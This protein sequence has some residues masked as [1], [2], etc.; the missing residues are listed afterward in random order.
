ML[1]SGVLIPVWMFPEQLRLIVSV[2]PFQ[3]IFHTPLDIYINYTVPSQAAPVILVQV[4]WALVLALMSIALW[5]RTSSR[6][7]IQGG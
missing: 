1:L 6:I 7:L 5:S 2:L 4:A 3:A